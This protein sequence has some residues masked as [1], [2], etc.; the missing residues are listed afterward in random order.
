M[1]LYYYD[2]LPA[3]QYA[4][5]VADYLAH[6]KKTIAMADY[7]RALKTSLREFESIAE[8]G[9][10]MLLEAARALPDE[11]C[12]IPIIGGTYN[13]HA[14]WEELVAVAQRMVRAQC[15]QL[16]FWFEAPLWAQPLLL[17]EKDC[18]RVLNQPNQRL[19]PVISYS[20]QLISYDYHID[21]IESFEHHLAQ[22]PRRLPP[23]V[24]A[25]LRAMQAR[26]A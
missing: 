18:I 2:D 6:I 12:E 14:P 1:S 19:Q 22:H 8:H 5:A 11:V 10:E 17:R 7:D 4:P 21:R 13:P 23:P 25:A 16:W 26:L 15:A 9:T 24:A 3:L 20:R